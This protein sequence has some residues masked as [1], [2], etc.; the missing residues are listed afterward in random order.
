MIGASTVF[1]EGSPIAGPASPVT[2][3]PPCP[4]SPSHCAAS[5]T[6]G[7]TT[8]FCEGK[9]VLLNTDIDTCG[10]PR[11]SFASTVFVGK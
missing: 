5:T 3:H 6:G 7:S 9:P 4:V 1:A 10:H 11:Q 8:V 2:P